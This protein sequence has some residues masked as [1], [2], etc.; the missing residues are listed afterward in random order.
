M[1][2]GY[3]WAGLCW[4]C[5]ALYRMTSVGLYAEE[6]AA[7]DRSPPCPEK[8]VPNQTFDEPELPLRRRNLTSRESVSDSGVKQGTRRSVSFQDEVEEIPNGTFSRDAPTATSTPVGSH[9]VTRPESYEV[10]ISGQVNGHGEYRTTSSFASSPPVQNFN[11][12][13][14]QPSPQFRA[15]SFPSYW[16]SDVT[17]GSVQAGRRTISQRN[18]MVALTGLITWSTLKLCHNGMCGLTLRRQ[19]TFQWVWQE[20]LGKLGQIFAVIHPCCLTIG[21]LWREWVNVSS[22][23]ARRRLIRQSF[24]AELNKRTKHFCSMA[25]AFAS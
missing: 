14:P 7:R 24:E 23:K 1:V 9:S 21:L 13:V 3:L 18:M 22:L 2:L 6:M 19:H 8:R 25:I 10:S 5:T 11:D 4:L 17:Q 16:G 15:T 20:W 12:S